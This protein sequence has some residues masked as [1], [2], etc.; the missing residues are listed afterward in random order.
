MRIISSIEDPSIIRDILKHMDL[1]L[2]RSRSP[3]K[4][5]A[6]YVAQITVNSQTVN[7]ARVFNPLRHAVTAVEIVGTHACVVIDDPVDAEE[8][9]FLFDVLLI[10]V[11]GADNK[12]L[13]ISPG[14]APERIG[15]IQNVKKSNYCNISMPGHRS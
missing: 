8:F 14:H 3:P 13:R 11:F 4:I 15:S 9:E 2:V 12:K 6:A 10:V 5:H 1:W 7:A